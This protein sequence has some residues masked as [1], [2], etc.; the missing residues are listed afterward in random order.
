MSH[1]TEKRILLKN[2]ISNSFLV[3]DG[4]MI[5]QADIDKMKWQCQM[6]EKSSNNDGWKLE[7]FFSIYPWSNGI[8]YILHSVRMRLKMLY[9]GGKQTIV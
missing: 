8:I 6:G 5:Q 7:E 3:D 1:Q 4:W 2:K 9:N